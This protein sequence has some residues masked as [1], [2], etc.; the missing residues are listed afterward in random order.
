M[1]IRILIL[2]LISFIS[3]AQQ[4]ANFKAAEKFSQENLS[5]MLKSTSVSPKWFKDSDRF[6]YSYTTTSGKNFYMVDPS[7]RTKTKLFDNL[8]FSAKLSE[9][10]NRPVNNNELNLDE[11]ELED[12][13]RTLTF[14]IDSVQYEYDIYRKT[15]KVGDTISEDE[16]SE[17]ASYAP[18][19]SYMVFAKN[20]NL[21]LMEVGDE[22]SVEIQ[23]TEDGERWFSYQRRHG[24][25][26]SDKRM[27]ARATW[28][29]DSKK[30][31]SNRSDAREVDELF[32]I[33]TLKD[34]RPELEIY[35]YAMPGEMNVP[36]EVLEIFDVET[37]SRITVEEDKYVDQTISLYKT[38]EKSDRLYMIR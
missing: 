16:K 34:P 33:N 9:L 11:I 3:N 10:T 21:Y 2:L 13:N 4:K 6:W 8:D 18:D 7:K 26:T 15:L 23:L 24:D 19:S 27:R 35:K 1:A 36:Q 14:H 30:I 5:K 38:M 25:T 12:D 20:H 28:F 31:Y 17:W 37:K 29:E 32:V 22:D